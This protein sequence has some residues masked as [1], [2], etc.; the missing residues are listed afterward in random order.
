MGT[1]RKNRRGNPQEVIDKKLKHGE[2]IGRENEKGITALKWKDKRDV[3][4]LSTK[5]STEM[6]TVNKKW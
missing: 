1:L 4:I 3:L 2:V 5:H 6:T